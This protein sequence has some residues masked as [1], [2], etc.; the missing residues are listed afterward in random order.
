MV[1]FGITC[2]SWRLVVNSWKA[3]LSA[4]YIAGYVHSLVAPL[5]FIHSLM[6][7]QMHEIAQGIQYLH[8]EDITHGDLHGVS[9]A[10]IFELTCVG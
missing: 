10:R 2:D 4:P 6:I 8:S 5:E 3:T 1:I 9:P 7:L